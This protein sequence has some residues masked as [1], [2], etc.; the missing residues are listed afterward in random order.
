MVDISLDVVAVAIANAVA[1]RWTCAADV[2]V[3]ACAS[4]VGTEARCAGA[5]IQG[6]L[7]CCNPDEHCV[8][9]RSY[10]SSCKPKSW[11]IPAFWDGNIR[12]CAENTH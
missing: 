11:R 7:G 4:C 9:R 5:G 8:Q 1:D 3:T 6:V 2:E 12:T 10:I